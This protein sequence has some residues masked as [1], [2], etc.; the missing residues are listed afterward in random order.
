MILLIH[1]IVTLVRLAGPGGL[2]SVVAESAMVRH[3]LLILNRGRKR[4]PNLR[5][6]DRIAAGLLLLFLSPARI[7][8]SAIVRK[9]ST[10]LHL[11]NLLRKRKY[12]LLFSSQCGRRPGPKGP[13]QELIDA[14]VAMKRRNPSWGCPR[15]AQQIALAFGVEIDKD[16]VRRIRSAHYRPESDSA[17]PSW[18]TLLGPSRTVCGVAI[19]SDANPPR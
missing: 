2:R 3:Q 7:L 13:N 18:L 4:G 19:G 5:G 14:V 1:V 11:H 9:P 16:V 8:G 17:G 6:S 10:W 15:I 12:R